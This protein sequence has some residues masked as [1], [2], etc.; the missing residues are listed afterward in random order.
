MNPKHVLEAKEY[1]V[2]M[3]L[4]AWEAIDE[5]YLA[6]LQGPS[7][8][9]L[10]EALEIAHSNLHINALGLQPYGGFHAVK[11]EFQSI[12]AEVSTALKEWEG[13]K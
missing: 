4:H 11:E 8:Q 9:K 12:A 5:V 6:A 1:R 2:K 3:E 13:E 7:V 10:V